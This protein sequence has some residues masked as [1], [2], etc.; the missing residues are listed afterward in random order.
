M[1]KT[2]GADTQ[3]S[4]LTFISENVFTLDNNSHTNQPILIL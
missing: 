2:S 4:L 3:Q 1:T